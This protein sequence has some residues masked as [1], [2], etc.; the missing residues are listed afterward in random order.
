MKPE[1]SFIIPLYNEEEVFE[2]LAT[3]LTKVMDTI[4]YTSEVVLINDGSRD[5]T[6]LLMESLAQRDKRFCCVF[7]SRNFGH[8]LALSAGMEHASGTIGALILDGDLQDPPELISSFMEKYNEGYDVIYAIRRDRKEGLVMKMLYSIYYRILKSMA[9]ITIPLDSGDFAFMSR[10][11]LNIIISM[12]E[13]SRFIRGMRAWVGF[14]QTGVEY[15][16]DERAYGASKYS[17]S[18]LIKLGMNGIFNFSEIP[19]RFISRLGVGTILLSFFYLIY[20]F[21]KLIMGI[22]IPEGFTSL[23]FLIT[24]FSGVQLLSIGV[25][26]E[27]L[28]RIFFQTKGRPLYI[29]DKVIGEYYG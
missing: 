21:V 16:R 8:Q 25:L 27:Y 5:K 24:L 1:L 17:I 19:I 18:S 23:V 6:Q 12:P 29:V 13:Q 15:S 7:L 11:V 10:R 9:S 22:E 2:E 14:K 20:V 26:G 3:R 28:I 4:G